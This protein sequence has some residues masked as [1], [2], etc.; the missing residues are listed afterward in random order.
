MYELQYN[1]IDVPCINAEKY[2][3]KYDK[4][5]S[6]AHE[7]METAFPY[8]RENSPTASASAYL[9]AA[10]DSQ[11]AA[12]SNPDIYN[13]VLGYLKPRDIKG[14]PYTQQPRLPVG[15]PPVSSTASAS[16]SASPTGG[17]RSMRRKRTRRHYKTHRNRKY[18]RKNRRRYKGRTVKRHRR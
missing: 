12:M 2:H 8:M 15:I 17:Y 1:G 6:A 5:N 14:M 9:N 13:S 3:E 10:S 16:A 18:S 4:L 11:I 7:N